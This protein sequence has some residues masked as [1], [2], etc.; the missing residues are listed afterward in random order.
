[1]KKLVTLFLGVLL[2]ILI[3]GVA[4]AESIGFGFVNAKDVA[5]RRG[6]STR[7]KILVRLPKDTCVWIKGRETDKKGN[8]WYHVNVG[9]KINYGSYDYSGWIKSEF[10]DCGDQIWHDIIT[11]SSE[12]WGMMALRKDGTIIT[13]SRPII[14]E[15]SK[16]EWTTGKNWTDQYGKRARQIESYVN[17]MVV[18][19]E[20][21]SYV[22]HH[23]AEA[24][25][26]DQNIRLMAEGECGLF[27]TEDNELVSTNNITASEWLVPK[28]EPTREE[29]GHVVKM[30]YSYDTML[31]LTDEGR[32]FAART[33]DLEGSHPDWEQW[34][35]LQSI[36]AQFTGYGEKNGI[37]AL[38]W[39]AASALK[40][41]TVISYPS[42]VENAVDGWEDMLDVQLTDTYVLGLR[43]DG[44][45]LSAGLCGN[46]APDVSGWSSIASIETYSDYCVGVTK[47]GTLVFA[48]EH[49]FMHEGKCVE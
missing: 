10:V 12:I 46:A 25:M 3:T 7:E 17:A 39:M 11:V 22:S 40:D 43:A 35:G 27:L 38:T 18:L 14:T 24:T 6:T 31:L 37:P 36:D 8:E 16:R 34:S 29:L 2:M 20:D 1:M 47:E 30:I 9:M 21:G 42:F 44:T 13:A 49:V 5:L 41:G 32:L 26:P 4:F 19:F 33:N 15:F 28:R 23:G 48:G 45:V